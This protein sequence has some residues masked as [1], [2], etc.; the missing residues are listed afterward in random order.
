MLCFSHLK[1][2][3]AEKHTGVP[4]YSPRQINLRKPSQQPPQNHLGLNRRSSAMGTVRPSFITVMISCFCSSLGRYVA[5][6]MAILTVLRVLRSSLPTPNLGTILDSS[7]RS[8]RLSTR[9]HAVLPG[10]TLLLIQIAKFSLMHLLQ[11]S[12][13]TIFG[14][15]TRWKRIRRLITFAMGFTNM[16]NF[17]QHSLT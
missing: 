14:P 17:F 10:V 4:L 9:L 12:I 8:A 11:T 7:G 3:R 6:A 5:T 15:K 16:W 13:G 1:N 2:V